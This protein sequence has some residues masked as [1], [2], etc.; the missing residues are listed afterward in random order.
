[1]KHTALLIFIIL[2]LSS[3]AR[4]PSTDE[5]KGKYYQ[6][7]L[8]TAKEEN[9]E[10][11]FERISFIPLETI[12]DHEIGQ[13]RKILPI[14]DKYVLL[15]SQ[16][17]SIF[18]YK[19]NGKYESQIQAIGNGPG[20]Y[21]QITDFCINEQTQEIK[22][23]DG[24]QNKLLTFDLRGN[25]I[26]ETK[27][28]VYPSPLHLSHLSDSLYA[29]DFQRC[30]N[31]KE[32][33]YQLIVSPESFTGNVQKY[34][35]YD[36]PLG[37]SFSPRTTLFSLHGETIYVPLY[38]STIYTV[39]SSQIIPRYTFLFGDHW[40]DQQFIDTQWN[41]ALDFMNR[42]EDMKYIYYFNI[43]ENESH[44][45]SDFMYKGKRY[46]LVVNKE[47]DHIY[48]QKETDKYKCKYTGNIIGSIDEQFIIALSPDEY[49]E[50][51]DNT[52]H[53]YKNVHLL[54]EDQNPVLMLFSF[55][56][57]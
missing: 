35:S 22:V 20:E 57:I 19:N 9:F 16:T 42:L 13:I 51:I 23:L 7:D 45:Y 44:I 47:N 10:S 24:I 1:M 21:V 6:I 52:A 4:T 49:N 3:C 43:L 40:V 26:H 54:S 5:S 25:F 11:I 29:F 36:K 41:D 56:R 32:W 33:Q 15:D 53:T 34:L 30:S 50:K 38:S 12:K 14:G 18:L 31:T 8:K 39:S 27:L 46:H 37:L 55:S 28:T 2:F 48:F 17:N